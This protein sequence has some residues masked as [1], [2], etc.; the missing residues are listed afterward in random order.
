MPQFTGQYLSRIQT[1]AASKA[2]DVASDIYCVLFHNSITYVTRRWSVSVLTNQLGLLRTKRVSQDLKLGLS[3][4]N[5]DGYLPD[6]G[7]E[8]L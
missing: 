2:K 8:R 3:Q 6:L 5:C 1:H 4:A 7:F